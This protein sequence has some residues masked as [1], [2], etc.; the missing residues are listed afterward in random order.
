MYPEHELNKTCCSQELAG[1]QNILGATHV[2]HA[3]EIS[4]SERYAPAN[5]LLNSTGEFSSAMNAEFHIYDCT[6]YSGD[7]VYSACRYVFYP[8]AYTN[9][10]HLTPVTLI[11]PA[12][13]L[14]LPGVKHTAVS[15]IYS[16]VH[17]GC[18]EANILPRR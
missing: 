16:C 14:S 10:A 5:V 17:Y 6:C 12:H 13:V 15:V 8:S 1:G 11:N 9:I 4:H 2:R 18:L 3:P 7:T